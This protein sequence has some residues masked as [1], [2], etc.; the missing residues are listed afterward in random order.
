V[1]ACPND[2]T[3]DCE[4]LNHPCIH[5]NYNS[6][7]IYGKP[8]NV[9][10]EVDPML[11]CSVSLV[12]ACDLRWFSFKLNNFF[13]FQG[14]KKFNRT[15]ICQ[16]CFQTEIWE[17]QCEQRGN[18]NSLKDPHY[19]TNCTVN[20]NMLCLGNRAFSKFVPCNWTHG[21]RWST[22]LLISITLGGFGADR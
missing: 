1:S 9:S 11:Q 21:Y 3:I 4:T 14:E 8:L 2:T 19:K 12:F 22:A 6:S 13:F 18:C 10:C 15:M 17:H 16:Y 20:A 7:C 5:C